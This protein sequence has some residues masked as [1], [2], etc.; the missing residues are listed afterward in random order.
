LRHAGSVRRMSVVRSGPEVAGRAASRAT[1]D[2]CAARSDGPILRET[3]IGISAKIHQMMIDTVLVTTFCTE[4][5]GKR[6]AEAV[7][8]L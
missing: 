5:K 3:F 1:P 8:A 4:I 7:Q 2:F 6:E